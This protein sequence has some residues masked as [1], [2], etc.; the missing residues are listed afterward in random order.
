MKKQFLDSGKIVGTH[1]I[2]GE[3]R[4]EPWCDSPEFLCAF[5]KLYL[6]ENGQTFIEVKSR[7]HKNITLAKIKG[8]DTIEAAEKFR[9][10]IVYINREDITLDEGVNFVQDLIGLEVRDAENGT[11]YGKL[12]DV[13]RTGA[14]DVYEI[15]DSNNKKY[16]APVIDEV[17]EK[18]NVDGGFVRIH[19]M[20]GIFDDED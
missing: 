18:I 9:G 3:V 4:I 19:P 11:V 17:V 12:T 13:L 16:L 1:G 6:D 20:K 14:N 8:V 10:K 15:T 5:K 7:P 2:K